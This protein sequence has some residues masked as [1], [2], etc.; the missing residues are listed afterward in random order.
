MV[1][2]QET[3]VREDPYTEASKRG[4]YES[5]FSLVNEQMG[6]QQ[7]PTGGTDAAGNPIYENV[8][9]TDPAT[10]EPLGPAYAPTYQIA[11]LTPEQ[12]Q[13]R[14]LLQENIGAGMPYI[15]S[16]LGSIQRGEGLYEEAATLAD[17]TRDDPYK[18]QES[19]FKTYQ[20]GMGQFA[21]GTLEDPTSGISAFFNPYEDAVVGQIKE[22]FDR[23]GKMQQATQAAQAVGQGAFGGSRATLAAQEADRNLNR[24]ELNAIAGVRQ[25]GYANAL[26]AAGNAYENQQRRAIQ[27]AQ[28]IGNLGSTYGQLGQRDIELLSNLG[29]NIANL[30]P[31]Q[32]NLGVTATNLMRGDVSALSGFGGQQQLLDQSVLD[33]QRQTNV[34]RQQFP[35][36]QLGYLS[37]V[38]NRVPSNQSTMTTSTS[39]QQSGLGQAIGYGIAGLGALAGVG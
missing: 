19:A 38:L 22:D 9:L 27:G 30:G 3:V 1:A 20:G 34:E 14:A 37:D 21:P 16:G 23:A 13:A 36:Q 12:R 6:Y 8:P 29:T 35:F 32:A 11:G 17:E 26:E 10:G 4:L 39:P 31:T 5:I 28:G 33:A 24:E 7:V 2:T 15:Q 18:Y 25:T